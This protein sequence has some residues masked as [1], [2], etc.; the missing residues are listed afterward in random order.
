MKSKKNI[1]GI[2]EVSFVKR[3]GLKNINLTLKPFEGITVS[4]PYSI[5]ISSAEKLI[6]EK[7]DWL[8]KKKKKIETI[9][10]GYTVFTDETDFKTRFHKLVIKKHQ[11]SKTSTKVTK[12]KIIISY[13]ITKDINN[14]DIQKTIRTAIE[15]ALRKEAK[16]YIPPRVEKFAKEYGFSYNNVYFKN[17]KTRWGSCSGVNN[18][19][20]NIHLMRLPDELI[21]YVILHEL[22]H[23]V[24][25]N[26]S[27]NFWNLL[28]KIS[29]DPKSLRKELKNYMTRVY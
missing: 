26:H 24:E 9:E 7:I 6:Y 20:F 14:N 2:G 29:G 28:N 17:A 5:S 18:L 19:N 23:T 11:S 22:V 16:E 1:T 13:P 8:K 12:D 4:V 3:K 25:K 27:K 15:R 10:S 21:D